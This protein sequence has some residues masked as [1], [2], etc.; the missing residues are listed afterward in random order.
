M[1]QIDFTADRRQIDGIG[2]IH[3]LGFSIEYFESALSAGHGTLQGGVLHDHFPHRVKE[4][5]HVEGKGDDD[6]DAGSPTHDAK[7]SQNDKGSSGN[8]HRDFDCRVDDG[9]QPGCL[10]IGGEIVG[11]DFVEAAQVL[12]FAVEALNDT[13]TGNIFLEIG[14]DDG[15]GHSD[16]NEG[17]FGMFLPDPEDQDQKG[18]DPHGSEGQDP[19]LLKK[20]EDNN[21]QAENVGQNG[22]EALGQKI[23][24]GS[25]VVL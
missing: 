9:G 10:N 25:D 20:P 17:L 21:R 6:A 7:A 8:S 18:Q 19:V 22:E 14:I 23:L 2:F 24:K 3:D 4:T 13:H 5:L 15:D 11:V 16:L 1:V 12:V